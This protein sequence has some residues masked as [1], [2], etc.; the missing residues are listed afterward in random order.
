[1]SSVIFPD[2]ISV[3]MICFVTRF[4]EM[5]R[6]VPPLSSTRLAHDGC[7]A[8]ARVCRV[9]E[10]DTI[11]CRPVSSICPSP[12]LPELSEAPPAPLRL[13]KWVPAVTFTAAPEMTKDPAA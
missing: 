10:S 7:V 5:A 13:T 2:L 4:S 3:C 8:T 9:A 1:M 12:G 11:V 6:A